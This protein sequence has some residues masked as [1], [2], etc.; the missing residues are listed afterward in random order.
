[1]RVDYERSIG[2]GSGRENLALK[3]AEIRV[4]DSLP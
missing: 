2:G 3:K 1:L 4:R